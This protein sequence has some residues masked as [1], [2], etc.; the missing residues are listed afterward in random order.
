MSVGAA[1]EKLQQQELICHQ[2]T[3]TEPEGERSCCPPSQLSCL[4]FVNV[5]GAL[6]FQN[7][8]SCCYFKLK[9]A[10]QSLQ[11]AAQP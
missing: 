2:D 8:S 4:G 3:C 9:G 7:P 10:T 5:N 6:N 1:T 11:K